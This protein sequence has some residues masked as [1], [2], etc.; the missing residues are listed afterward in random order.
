[1]RILTIIST[2]L[3]VHISTYCQDSWSVVETINA[4][5]ARHECGFVELNGKFYLLGGRGIKSVNE[6]NPDTKKWND[7]A[8]PPIEMHHF[9][10]LAYDNKIY[11]L[12]A[13]TGKYP[14]EEPISHIYI[15]DPDENTW[16]KGASIPADRRRGAAGAV[17]QDDIFYLVGGIVDGHKGDY[18]KWLDSW[19]P[20]TGAWNQLPDAPRPRD[21]FHAAIVDGKIYAAG[22]RTTSAKTGQVF[23]LT[24]PEVDCFD[25][26]KGAWDTIDDDLPTPR[27]G[28]TTISY[29]HY[30]IVIGGESGAQ[31][32]AHNEVEAFNINTN[33]W[34]TLS[35]LQRGRHGTQAFLFNGKIYIASGSGN[36]GGGPELE[37]LETMDVDP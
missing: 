3:F 17:I 22:G 27:A 37:S 33:S 34:E 25:L 7:L 15:F 2:L 11:V 10:A 31:K 12:G 36:R 23:E 20:V 18:V 19:D 24:I 29:D 6:Y 9:Q 8:P 13:L 26:S 32:T 35:S 28:S 4:P 14:G 16:Q 1:M 5:D 21:H 30:V